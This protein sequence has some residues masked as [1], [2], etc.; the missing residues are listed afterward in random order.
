MRVLAY[1]IVSMG[2]SVAMR[3]VEL[4]PESIAATEERPA[5]FLMV[6]CEAAA[7]VPPCAMP[8]PCSRSDV[9]LGGSNRRLLLHDLLETEAR[10]M[11][12]SLHDEAGQL[13]ALVYLKLD[14]LTG[15][16]PAAQ[17]HRIGDLRSMLSQFEGELRRLSHELRPMIL[18]DFG[19]LPAVD[20]LRQGI[21]RRTGMPVTV[22]G[23][24]SGRLPQSIETALYRIV[25]EA[26]WMAC[27][28]GA[29]KVH[30]SFLREGSRV[31][32]AIRQ[33]AVDCAARDS[34]LQAIRQR[35]DDLAGTVLTCVGP[36]GNTAI[37]IAIPVE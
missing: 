21:T 9:G 28:D 37:V 36:H 12:Q 1:M 11:A 24:V 5:I 2:R 35:V 6:R 19:L 8:S 15:K 16:L 29:R 10:R 20:F 23:S 34:A 25:H 3:E 4:V 31:E 13:L 26:L 27:Q 18:D 30:I 17:Q 22:E 14:E 7:S 33:V 32:C